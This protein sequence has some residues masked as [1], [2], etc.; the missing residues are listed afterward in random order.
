MSDFKKS[1]EEWKAGWRIQ[2]TCPECHDKIYSIRSGQFI[3]C[4]CKKIFI[5]QT[6][7]YWRSGGVPPS[8]E[9]ANYI[10]IITKEEKDEL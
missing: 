1:E 6:P 8:K 7:F 2:L 3:E 5:D 9:N 10:N 4:K